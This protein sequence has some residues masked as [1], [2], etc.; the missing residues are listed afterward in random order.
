VRKV[1]V[2]NGRLELNDELVNIRGV[3]LH[4][5]SFDKGLAIGSAERTSLVDDAQ[6]LGASMLRTH[7]PFHPEIHELAD[8]RGLLIWSEIPV[9]SVRT[10]YL[11]LPSVRREAVNELNQNIDEN[12]NHP[13]VM[14]WSIANELSSQPGPVQGDYIKRAKALANR[15]DPG[16]PVG[17]AF[18]AYP[19]SGC[20]SR[21]APLDVLGINEYFGWY[22]GPGGQIADRE[23]LS[24]YLDQI[25]ACYPKE[26][27]MVSEFGVEANREGPIE[28]K[29]SYAFQQDWIRYHLGVMATKPWLSGAIYW[30]LKEFRV[31]PGWDGGNPRPQSPIHQKG[32]VRFDGTRKPGFGDLEQ[33]FKATQ[34]FGVPAT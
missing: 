34:Q 11:A 22:T 10:T 7:Y 31:R 9:Y 21:Y 20:Q 15:L 2:V 32:V 8:E 18:A 30:A 25:R 4:E 23:L 3:G 1:A 28:E 13:S 33:L 19:G 12:R 29:G 17:L 14:I 5:D 26:A 6:A 27:V 24:G 16:R